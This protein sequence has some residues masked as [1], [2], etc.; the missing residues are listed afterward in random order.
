MALFYMSTS[1]A[2]LCGCDLA[3]CLI[4][5]MLG[6]EKFEALPQSVALLAKQVEDAAGA[7]LAALRSRSAVDRDTYQPVTKMGSNAL[8]ALDLDDDEVEND[9]LP[10]D[11]VWAV[12]TLQSGKKLR[13]PGNLL[14]AAIIFVLDVATDTYAWSMLMDVGQFWMGGFLACI[15]WTSTLIELRKGLWG[16][17]PIAFHESAEARAAT[18]EWMDLLDSERGFEAP[19]SFF[20]PNAQFR[21]C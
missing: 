2:R 6:A 13:Y 12:W 8:A 16:R 5:P 18:Q 19:L 11:E 14:R 9:G 21:V 10:R 7:R 3:R 20:D 15:C 17:A 4:A 1:L